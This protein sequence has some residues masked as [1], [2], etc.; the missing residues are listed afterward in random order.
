MITAYLFPFTPGQAA[1][2]NNITN[3]PFLEETLK[4]PKD[5]ELREQQ[6]CLD[7][8]KLPGRHGLVGCAN[9]RRSKCVN[10]SYTYHEL[11]IVAFVA[12]Y[13]VLNLILIYFICLLVLLPWATAT[14]NESFLSL[15][16]FRQ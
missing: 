5:P 8:N 10:S 9:K 6:G 4:Y 1:N 7:I 13:A 15:K 16:I 12:Q 2:K 14:V 3:N 11:S